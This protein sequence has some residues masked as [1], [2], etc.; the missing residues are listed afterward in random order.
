MPG[1]CCSPFESAANQQFDQK[2]VAASLASNS[3]CSEAHCAYAGWSAA[4]GFSS[5]N[6]GDGILPVRLHRSP[7]LVTYWAI[8]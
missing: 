8:T 1:C 3:P 6:A 5:Q 7:S 2:K 4:R